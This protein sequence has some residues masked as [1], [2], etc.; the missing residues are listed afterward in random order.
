MGHF[1][2]FDEPSD[3]PFLVMENRVCRKDRDTPSFPTPNKKKTMEMLPSHRK[4]RAI[5]PKFS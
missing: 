2:Y 3:V 5:V 4:V 1:I